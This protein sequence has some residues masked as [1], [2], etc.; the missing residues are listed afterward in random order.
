MNPDSTID[1]AQTIRR[2]VLGD[3]YVDRA[4]AAV[5]ELSE[6]YIEMAT[7][8]AWGMVWSRTELDRKS[9]SLITMAMLAALGHTRELRTHVRGAIR[10]G[11][12]PTEIC[13]V[14]IHASA[15]CGLPAAGVALR[16]AFEELGDVAAEHSPSERGEGN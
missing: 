8:Y 15:Y 1:A 9:R 14:F 16:T 4:T 3:E 12:T 10:N 5:N 13:E 11:C 6:P 7:L 2:E